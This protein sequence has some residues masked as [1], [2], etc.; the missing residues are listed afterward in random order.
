[1]KYLNPLL[2]CVLATAIVG[3]TAV[4]PTQSQVVIGDPGYYGVL[5]PLTGYTPQVWNA[6][7]I[8]ALGAAIAGLAALYLNVPDYQR[9][10]WR[11]YCSRYNACNRPVY[12]VRDNWYRDVYAPQYKKRRPGGMPPQG[13]QP[14]PGNQPPKAGP[15]GRGN[16]P[17]GKAA[18]QRGPGQARGQAAP[19][20][21]QL[22]MQP[23]NNK[24]NQQGNRAAA[25]PSQAKGQQSPDHQPPKANSAP[26]NNASPAKGSEPSRSQRPE[27]KP[28]K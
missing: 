9:N 8:V 4:T 22:R 1:M 23:Q 24:G 20:S 13:G 6:N 12:F 18:P 3:C 17:N 15:G 26:R 10:N 14:R 5:P 11:F 25:K 21:Q 19:S 7:P 2:K 27:H 28:P 16:P